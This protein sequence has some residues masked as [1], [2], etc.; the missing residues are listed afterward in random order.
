LLLVHLLA[1]LLELFREGLGRVFEFLLGGVVVF[2]DRLDVVHR[3]LD[4]GLQ[5]VV[6]RLFV[7]FEQAFR[8]GE[9]GFCLVA[10]LDPLAALAV[11][12]C[13]LFGFLFHRFNLL[14]REPGTA[15]DGDLLFVAGTLVLGRDVDDTVLVD[16]ERHLDLRGSGRGR[17]DAGEVELPEQFVLLCNFSLALE[18]AHLDRGL[19]VRGRGE[20]LRLLGRD[21][22]V[23]V[24]QPLEQSALDL[25]TERQRRHVQ[26]DDVVDV[27]REHAALDGRSQRDCL[28]W[29]D[30]LFWFPAD[31]VFDFLFDLWHPRRPAHKKY[32]VDVALG[33]ARVVEGLLGGPFCPLD[34]VLGE[35]LEL[36]PR[37]RVFEVDRA[38]V[39]RGDE[40]QVDLR[41]H[42]VREFDLG[43]LGSV[44]E[45]LERL[46]VLG[47]VDPVFGLE[48]VDEPVHDRPVPVV[49]AQAVVAV[50]GDDLVDTTAEVENRDVERAT[51]QVEHQH[52][53]V[54]IV[55]EA[56]GH[57]RRR[58]FVY[59]PFDVEPGD[60]AGVFGCLALPVREVRRHRDHR[61]LNLVAEVVPGVAL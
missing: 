9:R 11:L 20:N 54:G 5:I 58:G 16:G 35:R 27:T 4:V 36:R 28:V 23:A 47:Q 56:V 44:F 7:F 37:E 12:L 3:V 45:S 50:R 33:V 46:A 52:R 40:R 42:P 1:D 57:R 30:V 38:V 8:P 60:L 32:L 53:L 24:D 18:H 19:V 15:L 29:V 31:E 22:G 59:D 39:G 34:E 26:Q 21:G 10:G 41:L 6:D 13:V 17:R 48:L 43:F 55:V 2:D 49:A 14:V 25:D 61:L 51:P